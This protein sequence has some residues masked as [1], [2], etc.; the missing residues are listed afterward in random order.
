MLAKPGLESLVWSSKEPACSQNPLMAFKRVVR[1][2]T[3]Y[4][5]RITLVLGL[6][7]ARREEDSSWEDLLSEG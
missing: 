7:A 5:R 2:C 3:F 1:R 6:S 4:L